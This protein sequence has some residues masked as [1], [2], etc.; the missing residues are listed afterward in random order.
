MAQVLVVDDDAHFRG[1]IERLILRSYTYSVRTAATEAEA[2][3]EL[4]SNPFD[5]VL[6][7]LYIDGRKSW[8]TLSKI[9]KLPYAP[10]VIVIS[11]EDTKGNLEHARSLGAFDFIPKPFDFGR[12]KT[13]VDSALAWKKRAFVS[14]LE[15]IAGKPSGG[16]QE[17]RILVV[18]NEDGTREFLKNALAQSG[19]QATEAKNGEDAVD[20]LRK[21]IFD[22]VLAR[23][24]R[25]DAPAVDAVEKIR[26][27]ESS[28]LPLPV[29]AMVDGRPETIL[30]ALKAGADD[31]IS[32]PVDPQILAG[33]IEAHV[34]LRREYGRRLEQVIALCVKDSLTGS[35]NHAYFRSRLKEEFDRSLRYRRNLSLALI[36]LDPMDKVKKAL[37]SQATDRILSEVSN[38]IRKS[39]RSSDIVGRLEEDNF[40]LLIPETTAEKIV[41]KA[42]RIRNQVEEKAAYLD[43]KKTDIVCCMGLASLSL[44]ST[45]GGSTESVKSPDDLLGMAS[46]ALNRARM[47]GRN[48]VEVFGR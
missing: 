21:E 25:D 31:F 16:V 44:V 41:E 39:T 8:D 3:E 37:G 33:K 47:A 35:Y 43:G 15:A 45:D 13:T 32:P 26:K 36:G 24:N 18:D 46:M 1:I 9:R 34:R 10:P 6:L 20:V 5:L 40:A 27:A 7:D 12:I 14:T 22:A 2:W 19:F 23:V 11:C 17:M 48:R 42:S 28:S 29:I 4:E 38:V 30:S